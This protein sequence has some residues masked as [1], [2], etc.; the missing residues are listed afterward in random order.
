MNAFYTFLQTAQPDMASES[1]DPARP[2]GLCALPAYSFAR[3]DGPD[4]LKFLQGQATCDTANITPTRSVAG[5]CCN[6]KGRMYTSFL[7]A[8]PAADALLLR[9]SSDLVATTVTTL[10]KYIV[11]SKAEI[12]AADHVVIGLFGAGAADA[13]SEFFGAAPAA[14]GDSVVRGDNL[15]IHR[16]DNRFECWLSPES[17]V[18]F[19]HSAGAIL[20]VAT[21]ADWELHNIRAGVTD[22]CGAT[23][24]EFLPQML[25]MQITGGVSF[26]KGCYTGQEV[27]ARMQYR[28]KV[29]K[30]MYRALAEGSVPAIGETVTDSDGHKAGHIVACAPVAEHRAE[31]LA[32]I[33]NDKSASARCEAGATLSLLELP[34][35]TDP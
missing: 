2:S 23:A 9:M 22:I 13:V 31:V 33:V 21:A 30:R 29:K 11:F 12:C 16:D 32:V 5:A 3:I 34:Y 18:S 6:L 10:G 20:P 17:A 8:M 1:A 25:N 24:E 7:A 15:A 19:W 26:S 27:V 28:G 35:P 4:T 14:A